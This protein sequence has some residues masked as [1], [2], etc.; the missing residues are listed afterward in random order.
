MKGFMTRGPLGKEEREEV[1]TA[2]RNIRTAVRTF[3]LD[4]SIRSCNLRNESR[5][6]AHD[7]VVATQL[8][9]VLRVRPILAS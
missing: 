9:T 6:V 5:P 7:R 3:R 1:E 2:I 8:Q 4:P